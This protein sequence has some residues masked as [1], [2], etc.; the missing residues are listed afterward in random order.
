MI[1]I[2]L[3]YCIFFGLLYD[4]DV[5]TSK[6]K[7]FINIYLTAVKLKVKKIQMLYN[8]IVTFIKKIRSLSSMSN[9]FKFMHNK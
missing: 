9:R 5:P 7:Y 4:D 1:K 3:D 6:T 8:F 2:I